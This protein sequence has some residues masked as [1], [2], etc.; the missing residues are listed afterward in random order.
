V[1]SKDRTSFEAGVFLLVDDSPDDL[2]LLKRAFTAAAV[3]NDVVALES[4]QDAIDYL[5]CAI[6][7]GDR[8]AL[9]MPV[10][11]FADLKMPGING[12]DL[13]GW[14]RAQPPLK[15]M[16]VIVMTGSNIEKDV[17]LAYELGANCF[18]TKQSNHEEQKRQVQRVVEFIRIPRKPAKQLLHF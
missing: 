9:P 5:T 14:I 6:E 8:R 13:V 16:I 3:D 12:F 4:G 18:L 7:P 17:V 15:D 10:A 2:L 1:I 11:I